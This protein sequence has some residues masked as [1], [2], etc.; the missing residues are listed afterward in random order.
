VAGAAI[1]LSSDI[2][3]ISLEARALPARKKKCLIGIFPWKGRRPSE[4]SLPFKGRVRVG[5]GSA[6]S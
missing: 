2:G 3:R 4:D 6:C 1:K 5:M